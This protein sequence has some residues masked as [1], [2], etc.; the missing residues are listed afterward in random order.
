MILEQFGKRSPPKALIAVPRRFSW[1]IIGMGEGKK[2]LSALGEA[3]LIKS[4]V[5]RCAGHRA[6]VVTIK[7][8]K[9]RI[10]KMTERNCRKILNQIIKELNRYL[11][12][13][14]NYFHQ[15]EAEYILKSL[16]NCIV[17]RLRCLVWKQWKNPRTKSFGTA[18]CIP[19]KQ[20]SGD[21]R[22]IGNTRYS[23][24]Y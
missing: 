16:K 22:C 9:H 24:F 8:F 10:R 17:I 18:D 19:E 4:A 13:W 21:H 5:C 23:I 20:I 2:A 14:W 12:D 1:F 7:R 3:L 15:I 11:R 6:C